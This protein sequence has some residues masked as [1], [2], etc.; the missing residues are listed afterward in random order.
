MACGVGLGLGL[1]LV[2]MGDGRGVVS[3]RRGAAGGS[4]TINNI[5]RFFGG[6]L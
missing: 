1:G 6:G 4:V 2:G 3:I 5:P